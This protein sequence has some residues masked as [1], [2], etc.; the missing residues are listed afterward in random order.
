MLCREFLLHRGRLPLGFALVEVDPVPDQVDHDPLLP[1][2]VRLA[3]SALEHVQVRLNKEVPEMRVDHLVRLRNAPDRAVE[4]SKQEHHTSPDGH[5]LDRREESAHTWEERG[6][7]PGQV[8]LDAVHFP[9]DC[10]V[11]HALFNDRDFLRSALVCGHG[12]RA[13]MP[14]LSLDRCPHVLNELTMA[15]L[16]AARHGHTAPDPLEYTNKELGHVVA[17][18]R[19]E[20]L[21]AHEQ[22]LG[23]VLADQVVVR[24]HQ[25]A[26]GVRTRHE[27]DVL[28]IVLVREPLIHV[29][30][31]HSGYPLVADRHYNR[32][33]HH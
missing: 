26:W 12:Q 31:C 16:L 14:C 25:Q 22:P 23:K 4:P 5:G 33:I 27:H 21:R 8:V 11:L 28:P 18:V 3:C 10:R 20:L 9:Q 6:G 19:I 29:L 2:L 30:E 24:D 15:Q 17:F 13:R 32:V 1:L 7:H